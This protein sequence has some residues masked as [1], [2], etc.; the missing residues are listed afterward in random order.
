MRGAWRS[1]LLVAVLAASV[2][3][4]LAK[5]S[6]RKLKRREPPTGGEDLASFHE[7]AKLTS[8]YMDLGQVARPSVHPRVR[9]RLSS[10]EAR[11]V[12]ARAAAAF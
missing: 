11:R 9:V 10:G 8:S 6:R 3:L 7:G 1:A 5:L 2:A 12:M 4:A